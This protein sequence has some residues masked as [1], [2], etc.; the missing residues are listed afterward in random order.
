MIIDEL[1][2]LLGFKTDE[3]S[4]TKAKSAL[5]GVEA[6]AGKLAGALGAAG[7]AAGFVKLVEFGHA[8]SET[9][10]RLETVFGPAAEGVTDWSDSFGKEVGRSRKDLQ[11]MTATVG[12]MV[13]PMGVSSDA[14]ADM[15]KGLAELAVNLAELNNA[16]D[17]QTLDALK[18][19]LTG[20][21]RA[22]K[23]YGIVVDET[24]MQEAARQLG[25]HKGIKSLDEAERA[26]VAYQA[27]L[28]KSAGVAKAGL[29]PT[30]AFEARIQNLRDTIGLK[31]LP[32]AERMAEVAIKVIDFF[33]DLAKNTHLVEVAFAMLAPVAAA[34][35]WSI[36]APFLPAIGMFAALGLIIEDIVTLFQGG[37]SVLGRFL[38]KVGGEGTSLAFVENV[39]KGVLEF[40]R[41]LQEDVLPVVV[42]VFT[43][44]KKWLDI[45][46]VE[47][48]KFGRALG[49]HLFDVVQKVSGWLKSINQSLEALAKWSDEAGV[50]KTAENTA[51]AAKIIGKTTGKAAT[52]TVNTVGGGTFDMLTGLIDY[53]GGGINRAI[54]GDDGANETVRV[55]SRPAGDGKGGPQVTAPISV[56]NNFH[57]VKPGDVDARVRDAANSTGKQI[58]RQLRD[59]AA[60]M[61]R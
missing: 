26:Q 54:F 39:K 15:G 13:A 19:A 21:T 37:D 2:A 42:T 33:E 60:G 52:E 24:D 32:I 61:A 48:P 17:T 7:L 45:L 20:N 10:E 14:A 43:E 9:M 31:L 50:T 29:D 28:N 49:D 12:A 53:V 58:D 18:M 36:I 44:I 23:Q 40:K 3:A 5:S 47:L 1:I 41:V 55:T 6:A 35:A 30:E 51:E 38:D 46:L 27:V 4:A 11:Q 34:A 59:A 8:A 56:T 57:G 22:L 25:I 16:E